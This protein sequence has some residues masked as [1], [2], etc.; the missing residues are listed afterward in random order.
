MTDGRIILNMDN[1]KPLREIV[2]EAMR[3]AIV[4]GRLAPGE[5]LVEIKLADEMG[6][7]RTPVRE[8]IRKL[9]LEGFVI[10]MQ[11]KGAYVAGL[12]PKEIRDVFEI[13]STLESLAARLAAERITQVQLEQLKRQLADLE[14]KIRSH[15]IEAVVKADIAFHDVLFS[16]SGNARL[17][18]MLSNLREQIHRYRSM[19]LS[20]PG[21]MS[22]ALG[23]HRAIVKAIVEH[24]PQEAAEAALEHMDSAEASL[25]EVMKKV[26]MSIN[27]E[28]E[29]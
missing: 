2:F 6:V 10:M 19:S 7:S 9:E 25:I 28:R 5:R 18:S 20:Y 12:S 4:S 21:R 17:V 8:A 14:E 11:R 27:E 22:V 3:E 16:A 24:K 26:H 13:R 23:E 29:E 1:Y 15:E